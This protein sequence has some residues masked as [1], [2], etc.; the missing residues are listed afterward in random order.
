[1]QDTQKL[2]LLQKIIQIPTVD[3]NESAVVEELLTLFN[4]KQVVIERLPFAE[5]RESVVVKIGS[6]SRILAFSGHMDTV[7]AQSERWTYPPFAGEIHDGQI[8]GRGAN[9]MKS[10]TAAIF[11]AGAELL[12]QNQDLADAQIWLMGTVGEETGFY[13]AEM[14]AQSGQLD[15]V[16]GVILAEPTNFDVNFTHKGVIDYHITATGKPAHSSRPADGINAIDQLRAAM[17]AIEKWANQ[18]TIVDENLGKLTNV[19]SLIGGG[20]SINSVPGDAW[21]SGNI[22]TIPAYP[23]EMVMAELTALVTALNAVTPNQLTLEFRA[24]QPALASQADT[25]LTQLAQK[26][27][28]QL[29]G[30]ASGLIAGTGATEAAAYVTARPDLPV[31]II[32]LGD[33]E[34]HVIDEHISVANFLTGVTFYRELMQAFIEKGDQ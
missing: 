5:N 3:A 2:A 6:G 13:G 19:F 27:A 25:W 28:T 32:G 4:D 20:E 14:I 21:L 17:E 12:E 34:S 29:T 31:T 15:Q 9:D 26:T 16:A 7:A 30:K 23:N 1:M 10:G 22:R 24:P 18:K 8:Y 33:G 11:L